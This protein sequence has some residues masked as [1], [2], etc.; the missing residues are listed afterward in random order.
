VASG[1]SFR[2]Q[3][4]KRADAHGI[5]VSAIVLRGLENYYTLLARWNARINLTSLPLVEFPAATIDRLLIEPLLAAPYIE[6]LPNVWCDLG[7]GGGSPAIP[8]KL[9]R[10][11]SRLRMIESRGRKVAFLREA[12]RQLGLRETEVLNVRV[13]ALGDQVG[14]LES[15]DLL[16][17]RAVRVDAELIHNLIGLLRVGGRALLFGA[18]AENPPEAEAL[19]YL[20]SKELPSGGRLRVLKRAF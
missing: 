10:P 18:A 17:V 7:S 5:H 14:L 12:A 8:L 13:E 2:D 4:L 6:N 15:A 16:T 9:M 20:D 11:H 1:P 3:F 19:K